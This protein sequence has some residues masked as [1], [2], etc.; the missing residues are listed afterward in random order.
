MPVLAAVLLALGIGAQLAVPVDTPLPEVSPSR[1]RLP[2]A[3]ESRVAPPIASPLI[4]SR[5]LFS[6][7]RR[8]DAAG[9]AT[10]TGVAGA[11]AADA[12]AGATLTGTAR[13][14]RFAVAIVRGATGQPRTLRIGERFGAWRLLSIAR[15]S[16]MFS[17][18][19][20]RRTLAV[21]ETA[22]VQRPAA[23]GTTEVEQP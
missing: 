15:D 14:G 9:T 4:A 18:G 12:F 17:N 21:G 1:A 22:A 5:T 23:Q 10:A 7:T 3:A 19:V 6:P 20:T 16:A 8:I 11:P 13:A 2:V